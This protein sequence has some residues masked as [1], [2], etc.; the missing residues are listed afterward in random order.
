MNEITICYS[1]HR[2]ETIG[3]T[4]E[5]MKGFDAVILEEPPHEDFPRVLAREIE[6]QDHLLELDL[7][8]PEFALTQYQ[9]LQEL[10]EQ[11]TVIH[12]V[13]PY[14]EH[15]LSIQFFLAENHAPEDI[16]TDTVEH[17]VYSAERRATA[18]LIDYYRGAGSGSF[19]EILSL[20]N[21]FAQADADRF[22]LRDTLR[23]KSI[24]LLL[25]PDQRTYVEAGSMHLLLTTFLAGH[26]PR[27][28]EI[29]NHFIDEEVGKLLG[30][31]GN[32][33]SPG[34]K[35]TLCYMLKH[36]VSGQEA[37]LFCAQ[38]LIYSKIITKNELKGDLETPFP[39]AKDEHAALSLV[40]GLSV[41]MCNDLYKRIRSLPTEDAAAFVRQFCKSQAYYQ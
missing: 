39:H 35:L 17:D 36:P 21:A 32:L 25:E 23:A 9:L 30:Y 11:G 33:L 24:A 6:P 2:P 31:R 8:Y 1:M 37:E 41:A 10:Y 27:G 34:D 22:I 28:W 15:L 4:S 16:M 26:L 20:M 12:Q 14:L 7:E 13:E 18:K 29:N 3:L 38:S 40:E 5:I 19:R